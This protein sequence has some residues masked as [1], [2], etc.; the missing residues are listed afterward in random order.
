MSKFVSSLF[1]RSHS[2]SFD[3]EPDVINK[4]TNITEAQVKA[5]E[6]FRSPVGSELLAAATARRDV[7]LPTL[8]YVYLVEETAHVTEIQLSSK[9]AA[10]G[11][12][13]IE[14]LSSKED[15]GE[16]FEGDVFVSDEAILDFS[17]EELLAKIRAGEIGEGCRILAGAMITR[18]AILGRG[19]IIGMNCKVF[20]GV[21]GDNVVLGSRVWVGP[22]VEIESATLVGAETSLSGR[23]RIGQSQNTETEEVSPSLV[24][25][26]NS[27]ALDQCTVRPGTII[28]KHCLVDNN[29]VFSGIVPDGATVVAAGE[30]FAIVPF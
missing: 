2:A 6:A 27:C 19:V 29:P 16:L 26:G 21:L 12:P 5:L 3:A 9:L 17:E 25:L 14:V 30:S 10:D 11:L 1:G 7:T 24:I 20:G 28:G 8:T 23:I 15:K 4:E 22:D 18:E 13:S